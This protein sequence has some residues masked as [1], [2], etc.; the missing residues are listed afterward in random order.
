MPLIPCVSSINH[1]NLLSLPTSQIKQGQQNFHSSIHIFPCPCLAWTCLR[2][3]LSL[4]PLFSQGQRVWQ[5]YCNRI[6][7]SIRAFELYYSSSKNQQ[8]GR[9]YYITYKTYMVLCGK[10]IFNK[11]GFLSHTG[12]R[13]NY[14][15]QSM[16]DKTVMI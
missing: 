10:L 15:S 14:S 1:E 9:T 11:I 13:S 2:S 4:I 8:S 6:L 3:L 12:K 16:F 7:I 5:C